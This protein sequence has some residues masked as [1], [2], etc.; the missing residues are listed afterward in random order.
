MN[1][2]YVVAGAITT[3][4]LVSFLRALFSVVTQINILERG[5]DEDS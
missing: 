1:P 4:I 2:F 3:I 5:P